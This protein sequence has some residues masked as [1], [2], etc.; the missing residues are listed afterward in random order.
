M[1]LPA[2]SPVQIVAPSAALRGLV[3]S[4]W[5]VR[6]AAGV[7]AGQPIH[8]SP[9]PFAVLSVNLGVPNRSDEG[10]AVPRASLLGL[11]SRVRRWESGPET[12]FVMAMLTL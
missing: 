8:T 6:D 11:Q 5:I 4:Y 9:L 12:F 3:S 7:H 2:G 10:G 1:T